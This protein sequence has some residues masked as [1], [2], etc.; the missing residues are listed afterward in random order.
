MD[1]DFFS[2]LE[3]SISNVGTDELWK[4]TIGHRTVWLSPIPFA[5]QGKVQEALSNSSLGANIIN[6]SKRVTLANAIVGID[7]ID[8]RPYRGAGPVFGPVDFP[9]GKKLKVDLPTYIYHKMAGWGQQFIDDV[10]SIFADRMESHGKEN[11]KDVKFENAR[12]PVEELAD[13]MLRVTEL[14]IRLG[15]P[16]LVEEGEAEKKTESEQ[17]VEDTL[18]QNEQAP[19]AKEPE[20]T[21][22]FDP[23]KTLKVDPVTPQPQRQSRPAAPAPQAS[24]V[25]PPPR[26]PDPVPVQ[27]VPV[28]SAPMGMKRAAAL[29]DLENHVPTSS[30]QSPFVASPSVE[31]HVIEPTSRPSGPI[32][33]PVI[34]PMKYGRNPRF[35][36]PK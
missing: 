26:E 20:E 10:F 4:E 29:A 27:S 36:P 31:S 16:P 2:Q 33:P 21:G 7:E 35:S 17:F 23:F 32:P 14:R 1:A 18:A 34:D 22:P 6:E 5:G 30:P 19:E 24:A 15:L 25:P 12:A 8:L 9:G 11:V 3:E 28:A 13:M